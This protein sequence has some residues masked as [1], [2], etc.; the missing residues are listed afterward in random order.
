MGVKRLPQNNHTPTPLLVTLLVRT[1][2]TLQ[3]CGHFYRPYGFPQK[4]SPEVCLA[5]QSGK[6]LANTEI[7]QGIPVAKIL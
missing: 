7:T 1:Q 2:S 5:Y 6:M 4:T 3:S